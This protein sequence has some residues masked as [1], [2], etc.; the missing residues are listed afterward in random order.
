ML[1]RNKNS[2]KPLW[3]GKMLAECLVGKNFEGEGEVAIDW[4]RSADWA[5]KTSVVE[6]I[7]PENNVPKLKSTANHLMCTKENRK[8]YGDWEEKQVQK[9]CDGGRKHG[10]K[11][12]L[13]VGRAVGRSNHSRGQ[14]TG[15][16]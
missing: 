12:D 13:S 14:Q 7:S 8:R 6:P 16:S 5:E 10:P 2:H 4:P 1:D 9:E 3:S 11:E 15:G